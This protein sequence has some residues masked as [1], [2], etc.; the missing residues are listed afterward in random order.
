MAFEFLASIVSHFIF[1]RR[2]RDLF[3]HS[4]ADV[5]AAKPTKRVTD[6]SKPWWFLAKSRGP[7][8]VGWTEFLISRLYC[9]PRAQLST[10]MVQAN[11]RLP[12]LRRRLIAGDGSEQSQWRPHLWPGRF[13]KQLLWWTL[14]YSYSIV[15]VC[16]EV[17]ATALPIRE[18][19]RQGHVFVTSTRLFSS[20]FADI[21]W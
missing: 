12:Q 19:F 10:H 8:A 2:G 18:T 1:C 17:V 15:V 6:C 20:F 13:S 3:S 21:L 4:L 9:L 5:P 11:G 16:L 14:V 7:A